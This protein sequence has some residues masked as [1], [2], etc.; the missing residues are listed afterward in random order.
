MRKKTKNVLIAIGVSL[1]AIVTFQ[2]WVTVEARF[3]F[4]TLPM[5]HSVLLAATFLIG[6]AVGL[7]FAGRVRG[8]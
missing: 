8:S 5:P 4:A 6:V 1:V 2:N 7:L 3:L